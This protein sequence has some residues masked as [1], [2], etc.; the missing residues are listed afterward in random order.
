MSPSTRIKQNL[1]YTISH[2]GGA[3]LVIKR[4]PATTSIQ[5]ADSE[6]YPGLDVDMGGSDETTLNYFPGQDR[7]IPFTNKGFILC[8]IQ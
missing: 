1:F 7:V 6:I 8:T 3:R 5:P 4:N 2:S